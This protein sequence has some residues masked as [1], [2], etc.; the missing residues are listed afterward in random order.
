MARVPSKVSG[1]SSSWGQTKVPAAPPS[2]NR[3]QFA[4]A[5]NTSGKIDEFAQ[6]GSHGDFVDTGPRHVSAK[7]KEPG[8]GGVFRAELA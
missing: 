5:S 2:K 1:V 7:A 4:A 3:L 6:R 8:S